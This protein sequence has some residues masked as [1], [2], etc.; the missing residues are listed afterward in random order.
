METPKP[1]RL[2]VPEA[3]LADLRLRLERARWPDEAPGEPWSMPLGPD[4][5]ASGQVWYLARH[6]T[7]VT[8]DAW[9]DGLLV[10]LDQP[11]NEKRPHGTTMLTL[12]T[13]GLSDAAFADLQNR[14]QAWWDQRF[15]TV[16][17]GCD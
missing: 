2:E 14:W 12:T 4:V 6:Q 9:G 13:Y 17:P 7:G 3:A 10:V 15:E 5:E 16:A 11:A 8:V 1:F